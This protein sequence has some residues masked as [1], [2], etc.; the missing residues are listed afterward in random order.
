MS[1][2]VFTKEDVF[3]SPGDASI[4]RNNSIS[5]RVTNRE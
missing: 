2:K 3:I 5:Q 4:K 1:K